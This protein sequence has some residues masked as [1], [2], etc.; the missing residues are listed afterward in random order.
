M[1]GSFK[2][3]TP[4]KKDSIVW[5]LATVRYPTVGKDSTKPAFPMKM[6]R[7]SKA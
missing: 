3:S 7:L 1:I 5:N 6:E 4:E 2:F